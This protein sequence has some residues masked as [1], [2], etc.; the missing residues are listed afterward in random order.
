M[1]TYKKKGIVASIALA[2]SLLIS[3]TAFATTVTRGPYLQSASD[4]AITI[5]WRTDS[6]TNSVVKYGSSPSNLNQTV[7][8]SGSTTEHIVELSGLSTSTQYY[9]S[10]GSSSETLA[11]GDSSYRFTTSPTPGSDVATRVWIVGDSGTGNSNQIAVYNAYLAYSGAENTNLWLMLGDN[12]YTYGTDTEY[13][14][15]LFDIY[16]DF[17]RHVPLFPTLGNHDGYSADS[18]TESGPYYDIFDLPRNGEVGGLASGTEA[19]YSFDYANVHFICLD[20]YDSDRSA[21]GAMLTWLENDLAA[22]T[23]DWIIAYWH[24][25]PYSKGSHN[26]DSETN[27]VDM[28]ENVLPILEDYG[29]DLVFTGHSHAYERS[30]LIDSHYGLSSTFSS[31]YQVDAGNG[32]EDGDGAYEKAA[33]TAHAGTVYTVAGSSGK[34]SGGNLNHPAMY[35]SLNQLGS[36]VLDVNSNRLDVKFLTS[37]GTVADYYTVIKGADTTAPSLSSAEATSANSVAVTFSETVDTTT[38]ENTANYA[39]DNGISITNA[40]ASGSVVTLATSTLSSGVNYTLTVNNVE[41]AD[42][43]VIASNSATGFSYTSSNAVPTAGFTYTA[44]S[45]DVDFTDTSSDSDGSIASWSWNFGD[46]NTSS[47]QNPS[48]SYTSAGTYTVQLTVTDDQGAEDSQ[49]DSITVSAAADTEAPSVPTGLATSSVTAESVTLSWTASTDNV[50]VTGYKVLRDSVEVGNVSS[51]SFTDSGLSGSTSYSYTVVAYDAASNESAESSALSVTTDNATPTA[52]FS[53]SA[54]L[55]SVD[56]TDASSDSDGTVSSWQWDFGDGNTSTAQNPSHS[57][58]AA[59]SYS[60]TLTITDNNGGE[61]STAQT[62]AVTDSS[63][64]VTIELQQGLNSYT[65]AEDTYV[66]SSK[67]TTNYGSE[68]TILADGSDRTYGELISLLKWDVSS[69]PAGAT[70]T[71]ASITLQVFDATNNAYNLWEMLANWSESTA[72]WSNADPDSNSGDNIGSFSPTSTGSYTI[73]LNADGIALVQS[74]VDGSANYGITIQSASTTNGI[75]M[76]SSEYGTQAQ[77]PMLTVTYE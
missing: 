63:G 64:P 51:T 10:V 24:H 75:D 43:N 7:T 18:G 32:R 54:T 45:L 59:G 74:W 70:V 58:S 69:I 6:S 25:P 2:S 53:Y 55:L 40:S 8:V 11:G 26:S 67:T 35:T 56:F 23:Q 17:L 73:T 37:T 13:Q 60:V 16:P 62:V 9:Y 42:G 50:A 39:I 12:A 44:N 41:D 66:A 28:R 77:R 76:R 14:N 52:D 49:S 21:N 33:A 65:G 3:S 48:H 20:S 5:H 68:T 29:V 71:A 61:D 47:S 36:V 57:Y 4:S 1:H 27:L 19:Y 34:I 15:E 30:Y 38:A 31:T 46:G 72:T 22:T